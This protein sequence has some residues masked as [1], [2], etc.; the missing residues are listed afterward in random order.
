VSLAPDVVLLDFVGN[1]LELPNF[2]LAPADPWRLDHCYLVD[3]A[4]RAWRSSWLDP[5]TPFVW[6]PGDG[7]GRFE[8]DPARVP[9]QYRHLVGPEAFARAVAAIV[10]LG[11]AHGF[12][13]LVSSV[14]ELPAAQAAVC[15]DLEL[16]MLDL[17]ARIDEWLRGGGDVAALQL[18]AQD[19]HPTPLVHGW[20]ADAVAAKLRELRWLPTSR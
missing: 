10:D 8:S 5:R 2:L 9:A 15:R 7:A 20:W 16:P 11:R 19:P 17:H 18:S 1:D 3:V 14:Y 12:H 4:R 13:V 6:A